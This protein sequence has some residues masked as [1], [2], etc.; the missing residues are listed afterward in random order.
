MVN[1]LQKPIFPIGHFILPLLMLTHCKFKVSPYI[2]LI[3]I[4][5]HAGEIWTKIVWSEPYKILCVLKKKMVKQF[6]TK[7]WRHFGRRFCDWKNCFMLKYWFKDYHI[8]QC[9]KNYA[10]P[11]RVTRLKVALNMADSINLNRSLNTVPGKQSALGDIH[12]TSQR[13]SLCWNK[14]P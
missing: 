11:T 3:S 8:F 14:S 7:C 2:I 6:L 10:S 12:I 13:I 1:L 9:S 5:P 4:G